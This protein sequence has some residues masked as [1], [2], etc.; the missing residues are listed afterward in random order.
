MNIKLRKI[1]VV[2]GQKGYANWM[3]GELVN[4][5]ED[6][7]LVVFTGGEDINPSL[8]GEQRHHYTSFNQ[9]RDDHEMEAMS[10]AIKLGKYIWGTCR[11]AQ[12]MCSYNKG[13]VIQD[14]NHPSYHKF[15]TSW[16][17]KEYDVTSCHHQMLNTNHCQVATTVLGYTKQLSP[18]HTNGKNQDCSRDLSV[19]TENGVAILKEPEI[20]YFHRMYSGVN[21]SESSGLCIQGHPE[22]MLNGRDPNAENTIT[23]LRDLL[24]KWMNVDK[25]EL[26]DM[27]NIGVNNENPISFSTAPT[28]MDV[29]RLQNR[30]IRRSIIPEVLGADLQF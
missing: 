15:T 29:I 12:L 19:I 2:G 3:E 28:A 4:R 5:M 1:F 30:S 10:K 18:Y 23:M 11:G 17:M 25:R 14:V 20:V 26:T 13:K 22:W 9:T 8:Y 6:C 21:R 24:D 16:D 27:L 7:D